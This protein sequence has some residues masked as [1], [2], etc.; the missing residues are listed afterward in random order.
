MKHY[1]VLLST[2]MYSV[3]LGSSIV[4]YDVYCVL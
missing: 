1:Q 2:M 4:Y 3:A